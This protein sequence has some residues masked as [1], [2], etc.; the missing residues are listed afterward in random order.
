MAA[1][2]WPTIR[3]GQ[4]QVADADDYVWLCSIGDMGN[5]RDIHPKEK[6]PVG[7]RLSLLAL[8]H[9]L[10]MDVPADAPRC[11]GAE[12]KGPWVILQF[13]HAENGLVLLGAEVNA[14]ELLRGGVSVPFQAGVRGDRLVLVP[15]EPTTEPLE[16]RFAQT[17]WY[18]INLYN[19]AE[20][21]VLPFAVTC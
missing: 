6:K 13:D 10:E 2:D 11:I 9:L 18:R 7:E 1:Q 21:P 5:K 12:R 3:A 8:R 4:Q 15:E 16:V 19:S 20:I 17:N 14:L